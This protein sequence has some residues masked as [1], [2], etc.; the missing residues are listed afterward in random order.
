[1]ISFTASLRAHIPALVGVAIALCTTPVSSQSTEL[2]GRAAN[3]LQAR[4]ATQAV[5]SKTGRY[6]L[7]M[8][9]PDLLTD[10]PFA[11]CEQWYLRDRQ[12]QLT[13]LITRNDVGQVA[14]CASAAVRQGQR[15]SNSADI[16]ADG[17]F[18]VFD[19]WATNLI[20]EVQ[21]PTIR[22][23]LLD[24]T[25]GFVSLA[26]TDPQQI[27]AFPSISDDGRRVLL[28][29]YQSLASAGRLRIIDRSNQKVSVVTDGNFVVPSEFALSGDGE[30]VVYAGREAALPDD[31]PNQIYLFRS[32][33]G[34]TELVSVAPDGA[35]ANGPLRRPA[36][37]YDGSVI[38]FEA[39]APN[40]SGVSTFAIL[41]RIVA[42]RRYVLVSR[43]SN[44]I[45][46][47]PLFF[48][49]SASISDDG[50]RVAFRSNAWNLPGGLD[51]E[52]YYPQVHV[53]DLAT[54]RLT[55]VSQNSSG[56]G[57]RYGSSI[58]DCEGPTLPIPCNSLYLRQSPH[59]SGDGRFIAFHSSG[60]NLIAND[61]N[62]AGFDVYVRDLGSSGQGIPRPVVAVPTSMAVGL[63][64]LALG[65]V[66]SAS[67]FG[68]VC[69]S[70]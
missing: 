66:A 41:A 11:A 32:A 48:Q 5:I 15:V 29:T 61:V 57:A 4:S 25:T 46:A 39:E 45:P 9:Q 1:M 2:V 64:L 50:S 51:G 14:Q 12:T 22:S 42:D 17:R 36:L 68:R 24:R 62:G 67:R 7:F 52:T 59:I 10:E 21:P 19:Y 20:A 53:F 63:A 43:D 8:G 40:L 18:V 49:D 60:D 26:V 55:L 44:G 16:S 33:T 35:F 38:A 23:Y 31:V 28:A 13:E 30:S 47:Q 56:A 34:V 58:S 37:N 65:L 69:F 70:Q 54:S 3:G 27:T 6:V